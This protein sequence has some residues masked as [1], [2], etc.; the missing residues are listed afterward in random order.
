MLRGW[1]LFFIA[2]KAINA[3]SSNSRL[4]MAKE[5]SGATVTCCSSHSPVSATSMAC[6]LLMFPG[7]CIFPTTSKKRFCKPASSVYFPRA[8]ASGKFIA[9]D[10]CPSITGQRRR[11]FWPSS[12][13]IMSSSGANDWLSSWPAPSLKSTLTNNQSP[14]CKM[15]LLSCISNW[16][17]AGCACKNT[18]GS[19]NAKTIKE[20]FS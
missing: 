15:F 11:V 10:A 16:A 19:N 7:S 18:A 14:G 5:P 2:E 3:S 1:S 8:S 4:R 12:F 13:S 17:F 20:F 9:P 6:I